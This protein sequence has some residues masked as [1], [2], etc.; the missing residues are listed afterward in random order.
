[1]TCRLLSRNEYR[2][3]EDARMI[4]AKQREAD[5]EWMKVNNAKYGWATLDEI[6]GPCVMWFAYW[7]YDPLDP[8]HKARRDKALEA[9]AKGDAYFAGRHYYLSKFYWRD[10]S[11]KRPPICVLC[12]NGKEWCVDANSSNGDG[13]IVTGEPP[14]ITCHPSIEVL[15]YH[16]FLTSGVFSP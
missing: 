2:V 6:T 13:W 4:L 1:M 11:D 8:Q 7:L 15:G 9:L 16:G 10:W 3:A 14:A 5:P 12:P